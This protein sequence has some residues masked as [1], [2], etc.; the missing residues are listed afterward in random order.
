[1]NSPSDPRVRATSGQLRKRLAILSAARELFLA[2]GYAAAAVDAIAARASVSKQT[3]YNHFGSKERLFGEMLD[4]FIARV[5]PAALEAETSTAGSRSLIFVAETLADLLI[6]PE[7]VA[8]YRLAL[9]EADRHPELGRLLVD[10]AEAPMRQAIADVLAQQGMEDFMQRR[11]LAGAMVG[12]IKEI[13]LWPR[14]FGPQEYGHLPAEVARSVVSLVDL[15]SGV[16]HTGNA[17]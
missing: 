11:V 7:T 15:Y 1:M 14:L 9:I 12:G 3:L 13:V 17:E 5:L 6:R 10:R 4:E 2:Q 16:L 8:L